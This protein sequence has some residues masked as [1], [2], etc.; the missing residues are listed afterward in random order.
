MEAKEEYRG[1]IRFVGTEKAG[2][3][4]GHLAIGIAFK[5][6]AGKKH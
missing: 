2:K 4:G 5:E 3:P 6:L 1:R